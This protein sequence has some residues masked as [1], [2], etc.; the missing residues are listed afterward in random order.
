MNE[1]MMKIQREHGNPLVGGCGP[2][3]LQ[4]PLFLSLFRVMNGFRPRHQSYHF[5]SDN[6]PG[7]PAPL[8]DCAK[9]TTKSLTNCFKYVDIHGIHSATV[10]N[11]ATAKVFGVP[12]AAA[13]N[14]AGGVLH[15][16]DVT[17]GR[18]KLVAGI[19]ILI[20]AGTTFVTQKQIMGRQPLPE[21]PKQRQQ[22][23]MTQRIFLYVAPGML[24]ISGLLFPLGVLFYWLTTNFWSVGQQYYVLKAMPPTLAPGMV[25]PGGPPKKAGAAGSQESGR[26]LSLRKKDSEAEAAPPTPSAPLKQVRV[27]KS[28]GQRPQNS[29]PGGN[30]SRNKKKKRR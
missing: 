1:E 6:L 26:G 28:G 9:D 4:I 8:L 23:Q 3:V 10:E 18:T 15:K 25:M 13:F 27:D 29:R 19:M 7:H 5:N 24:M 16:L 17:S 30:S 2:I 21:D 11:I 22:Q 20:M 14:S 12:I